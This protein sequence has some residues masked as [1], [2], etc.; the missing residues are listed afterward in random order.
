MTEFE[1]QALRELHEI[2]ESLKRIH[3]L[4]EWF[5]RRVK[6]RDEEDKKTVETITTIF[7]TDID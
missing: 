6:Q 4:A 1:E 7:E 2:S 3:T 5:A